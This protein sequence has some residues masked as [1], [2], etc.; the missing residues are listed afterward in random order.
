MIQLHIHICFYAYKH[1]QKCSL[2]YHFRQISR[3]LGIKLHLVVIEH[4]SYFLLHSF[5]QV[6]LGVLA[7]IWHLKRCVFFCRIWSSFQPESVSGMILLHPMVSLNQTLPVLAPSGLPLSGAII[8]PP[9]D[10][11]HRGSQAAGIQ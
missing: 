2:H 8:C 10:F 1:G 11:C 9:C 5:N 6:S 4:S 7:P 3:K